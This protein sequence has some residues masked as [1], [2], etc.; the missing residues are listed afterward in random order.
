MKKILVLILAA[1]LILPSL[2]AFA[3]DNL[4]KV[5]IDN[6]VNIEDDMLVAINTT[7]NSFTGATIEVGDAVFQTFEAEGAGRY[8]AYVDISAIERA[9]EAEVKVTSNF[10]DGSEVY[11]QNV[12]FTKMDVTK[13]DIV[14]GSSASANQLYHILSS[15]GGFS[16]TKWEKMSEDGSE[17]RIVFHK[18]L[19]EMGRTGTDIRLG[20]DKMTTLKNDALFI[21]EGEVMFQNDPEDTE[22][23]E[24]PNGKLEFY[25]RQGGK[26]QPSGYPIRGNDASYAADK[27]VKNRRGVDEALRN[28]L[29]FHQDGKLPDGTPFFTNTWYKIRFVFDAATYREDGLLK[30]GARY[31]LAEMVDG[32]YTPYRL[33][34]EA[35]NFVMY[36]VTS[37]RMVPYLSAKDTSGYTIN[38]K[39]FSY[40]NYAP[41][42]SWYINDVTSEEDKIVAEFSENLGDLSAENF[43]VYNKVG[44]GEEIA[45][46]AVENSGDG[47]YTISLDKALFP[48]QQYDILLANDIISPGGASA[49]AQ[50]EIDDNSDGF[51]KIF[52]LSAKSYPLNI[53]SVIDN[54]TFAEITFEN[55]ETEDKQIIVTWFNEDGTMVDFVMKNIDET[56]TSPLVVNRNNNKASAL[57]KAYVC[58][59]SA[60]G[61]LNIFDIN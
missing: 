47:K 40:S 3:A 55:A 36:E 41:K 12:N 56:A 7:D 32:E 11:T 16:Q 9:G 43:K 27:E 28:T 25:F 58:D 23:K 1:I 17:M 20:N 19:D 51:W 37:W 14:Y 2:P 33:V 31:Y 59:L 18:S 34:C 38:F 61:A 52:T 30:G 39:N 48:G 26:Y 49:F 21:Y 22:T 42:K 5:Y 57:V 6:F 50:P 24:K 13:T 29:F 10:G 4:A 8:S 60:N 15:D 54:G 45:V 35:S 53:K 46:K 44:E